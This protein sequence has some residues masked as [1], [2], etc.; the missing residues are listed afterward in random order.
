MFTEHSA[1]ACDAVNA[2]GRDS[3]C[4]AQGKLLTVD[5]AVQEREVL[6]VFSHIMEKHEYSR[7]AYACLANE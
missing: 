1:Q 5:P 4:S 6:L 7:H 2:D 3:L